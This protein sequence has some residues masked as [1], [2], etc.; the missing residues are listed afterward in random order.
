[1]NTEA[2][3][4]IFT[5]YAST[6]DKGLRLTFETNELD[7]EVVAQVVSQRNRYGY[8]VFVPGDVKPEDVDV[9]EYVPEF[10]NDKTPSQRLRGVLYRLWEQSD[11]T[12]SSD[13]FYAEKMNE[14]INH[15]KNKLE[16]K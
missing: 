6:A 2:I 7:P 5:R 9:P 3:P 4:S 15:F 8:L 11:K 14:I 12:N 10:K 16:D 13:A 1:M